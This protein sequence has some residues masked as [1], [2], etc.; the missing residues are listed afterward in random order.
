MWLLWP[1]AY[2]C[3]L[4]GWM[5]GTVLKLN[6]FNVKVLTMHRWFKIDKA[7]RDLGYEPIIS[8]KEGWADTLLWF[9]QHWLPGFHERHDTSLIGIAKASQAKIDVQSD[10]TMKKQL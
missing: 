4:I 10:G 7:H 2:I 8:Y 1:L 3:E 6:V 5:S 9:K